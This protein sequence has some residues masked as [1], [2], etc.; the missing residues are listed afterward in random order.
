MNKGTYD[1]S[2]MYIVENTYNDRAMAA[3]R[4][5]GDVSFSQGGSFYD[6]IYG[7]KTFGLV[8]EELMRPGVEYGD[9]L[10][11]HTEL[12]AVTDAMVAAI[13]PAVSFS[14]AA[15]VVAMLLSPSGVRR[16]FAA[17][18]KSSVKKSRAAFA[19]SPLHVRAIRFMI[20]RSRTGS[21]RGSLCSAA[22]IRSMKSFSNSP[23]M[24]SSGE[25]SLSVAIFPFLLF[26]GNHPIFGSLANPAASSASVGM[27]SS[28]VPSL[29]F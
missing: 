5:S 7:M 9:T 4:T 13:A 16:R 3:I 22:A 21:R 23:S 18:S 28:I 11:D 20:S 6:V 12:S 26:V 1:F 15:I 17:K 8:P 10:S 14:A 24:R 2:E 25:S 19:V 27:T 29:Y